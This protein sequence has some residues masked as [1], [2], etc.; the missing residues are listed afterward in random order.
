MKLREGRVVFER[1]DSD[2]VKKFGIETAAQMFLDF[3]NDNRVPFIY[4]SSQLSCVLNVKKST[5]Y[6]QAKHIKEFY[7]SVEI[8]KKNGGI[9][10][11]DIPDVSLM[12]S[13]RAIVKNILSKMPVSSF[14]TA[15]VRHARIE[16]NARPH[17]GKRYLLK[18]DITDFFGSIGFE[19][20]YGRVF[21][22]RNFPPHIGIILTKL[23]CYKGALPQGAPT[24]PMLS[25]LVMYRFDENLGAWCKARRITYTRY[26]DDMTF[27]SDKPLYPVY[28][29]VKNMLMSSGFELNEKKT[30]FVTNSGRQSVTGITVNEKLSVSKDYK[31][32]LRQEVFYAIKFGLE[33][34]LFRTDNREF[35]EGFLPDVNRYKN[36]LVGRVNYVL[37]IE[38]QNIWFRDAKEKLLDL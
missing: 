25:N 35:F 34:S 3:K 24:S 2:F 17:I 21:N 31:R 20:I 14:A 29:K 7:N 16:N 33:N 28:Q 15:Y 9:R 37:Q 6:R 12:K 10:K 13:Q 32:K 38:P 5:L 18:L 27:S 30:L 26:C 8:Q 36:H 11:L 23:C 19:Q 22:S 4:D 1:G